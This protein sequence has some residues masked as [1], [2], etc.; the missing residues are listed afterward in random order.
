M[1]MIRLAAV[2]FTV[3]LALPRL[4]AAPPS[5][6]RLYVV[7]LKQGQVASETR[8]VAEDLAKL[9]GGQLG[10]GGGGD[11][12]M[13]RLSESR[14][15]LVS[16]DPRVQSVTPLTAAA[17][18]TAATT[19]TEVVT[20]TGGV[21][22]TYDGSG[23]VRQIGKDAFVYDHVGRLVQADVN[24]TRRNF[25]YDKFGNRKKCIQNA[26][27]PGE[28]DCQ[29]YTINSDDNR[30]VEA[31]YDLAGA[32]TVVSLGIHNYSYDEFTMLK[33]DQTADPREFLY[34]ASDE[35]IAVHHVNSRSWRW[36]V[37][38]QANNVIREYTSDGGPNGTSTFR[39]TKDYV[40]RDKLLLATVQREGATVTRYH[41]HLDH[42]GT[43]RRITDKNDNMAGFHDYHPF[44]P[45]L[46]TGRDEPSLTTVK[47]TGHER[48]RAG[49]P[50]GTLDYMHARYYNPDLGRFLT[51][52]PI[53]QIKRAIGKPQM[54]NR[55]TYAL[56]NPLV[57]TD[58][59]G[60]TVYLITYTTGNAAGDDK[61]YYAAMTH[62]KEIEAQ[63]GF[64]PKVDKVIVRGV[65]SKADFKA[66]VKEA[67]ALAPKFGKVGE[68]SMFSH[69]GKLDGPIFRQGMPGQHQFTNGD[70]QALGVNWATD[71]EAR[72]YG[73]NTGINFTQKFANIVGVPAWGYE[74]YAS[75][76]SAPD[77]WILPHVGG[78]VYLINVNGYSNGGV[79]GLLGKWTGLDNDAGPM[80]RDHP[81]GQQ[82]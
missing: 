32:G 53:L 22:V 74:A 10:E 34:T 78:P 54:W 28:S 57:Y 25:E 33:R 68:V 60:E 77:R 6:E 15:R 3:A 70:L 41:Y 75:F 64:D 63:Q 55:Y 37:R 73:C 79:M 11:T 24:G 56:N 2:L 12:I 18:A 80:D 44:G 35:R 17:V 46:S 7:N 29:G 14:A 31:G 58:P 45:E 5:H 40:W 1:R 38:D 61:F 13:M 52:D 9:Y 36:T 39:W 72:F 51:V 49:D 19:P 20:W 76:S 81:A 30:I 50:F 59:T 62:K 65:E 16:A 26:G 67:N 43:P 23:N 8:E 69:A 82:P 48:D 4:F 47:Y 21:S 71:G 42:L 66:A 27:K